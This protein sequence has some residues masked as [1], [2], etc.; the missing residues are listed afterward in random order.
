M[1]TNSTMLQLI[2][3]GLPEVFDLQV[4]GNGSTGVPLNS[5]FAWQGSMNADSYQITVATDQNLAD[6]IILFENLN[7][8]NTT[9]D[10]LEM[11]TT[12]YWQVIAINDCGQMASSIQ[13][14]TTEG[15]FTFNTEIN[16]FEGCPDIES[17]FD[18]FVGN[19]FNAPAILTYN[20]D[21]PL[22]DLIVNYSVDP[23][24]VSP[25]DVVNVNVSNF[26]AGS[27]VLT[28]SLDDGT[29]M[30]TTEEIAI[31]IDPLPNGFPN[32]LSPIEGEIF[33][34]DLLALSWEAVDFADVYTVEVA[35]DED[36]TDII[37]Q[38]AT[39]VLQLFVPLDPVLDAGTYYW[40]VIP[41]NSCGIAEGDAN[42]GF[43]DAAEPSSTTELSDYSIRLSPNPTKD[44]AWLYLEGPVDKDLNIQIFDAKG[45]LLANIPADDYQMQQK[46]VKIDLSSYPSGTYFIQLGNKWSKK[47]VKD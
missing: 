42:V 41:G 39:N 38:Q 17:T 2:I 36:F 10:G 25:G 16:G 13:S 37:I 9:V 8:L 14:F 15:D 1:N 44:I 46:Q 20:I 5:I 32:L 30:A 47:L 34:G 27:Y 28:F 7:S 18:L 26:D 11:G 23:N 45:Q 21:P 24:A 35:T 12:Y 40:R 29:S 43:F 19:S 3:N 31:S 33:S 22:P 4:P 6:G